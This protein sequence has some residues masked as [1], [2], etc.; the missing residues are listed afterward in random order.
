MSSS[1]MTGT[2]IKALR[3]RLGED[4]ATFA[5][6]FGVARTTIYH[7][8]QRGTPAQGPGRYHVERVLLRMGITPGTKR[9]RDDR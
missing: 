7:W 1:D 9:E 4:H 3:E 8:E 2:E 5:Q 6:R